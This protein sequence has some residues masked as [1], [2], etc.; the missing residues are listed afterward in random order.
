MVFFAWSY[1]RAIY[2]GPGYLTIFYPE[3]IPRLYPQL[4][5][6]YLSGI[7]VTD[8]Q[9][10]F[11]K[12]QQFPIRTKFFK[13]AR[14]VVIRPDHL[15]A[16][17]ASFVGKRNHKLFFL[18]NF[19]G[20]AY[21]GGHITLSILEIIETFADP[22][23]RVTFVVQI[24]YLAL[25]ISFLWLTGSFCVQNVKQIHQNRTQFEIMVDIPANR[26]RLSPSWKNWEEVFGSI[27][28]WYL[29]LLPIQ[30][31]GDMDDVALAHSLAPTAHPLC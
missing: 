28:Q 24:I 20:I 19:W 11:A 3:R 31:F 29:W 16:W 4:G 6:D 26:F 12:D 14:R 21:I 9:R 13:S 22:T 2:L 1:I 5:A 27:K 10:V 25:A 17:L 15:C 23:R 7:A 30:A 18:F 8:E